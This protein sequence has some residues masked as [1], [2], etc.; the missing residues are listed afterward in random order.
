MEGWFW[1]LPPAGPEAPG[2]QGKGWSRVIVPGPGKCLAT[3][4]VQVWGCC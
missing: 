3:A 2:G 4:G 1:R